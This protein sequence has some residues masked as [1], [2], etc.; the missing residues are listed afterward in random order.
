MKDN[1]EYIVGDRN[2]YSKKYLKLKSTQKTRIG[3]WI[4]DSLNEF[5]GT[6][7][8][9]PEEDGD[10]EEVL[11]LI[12]VHI[13]KAGIH[14]S[15]DEI[16]EHYCSCR[17]RKINQ[18]KKKMEGI[19]L[20]DLLVIERLPGEFSVCKVMDYSKTDLSVSFTF[21][22]VTDEEYSL[23]CPTCNVP[24]NTIARE[25]AWKG[26]RINGQLD[27]SLTGILNRITTALKTKK[28]SLFAV[29]TYNTDYVFVKKE[30]Y[31]EALRLVKGYGFRIMDEQPG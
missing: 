17:I 27:F 22:G 25:D 31:E 4:S 18:L 12:M 11:N 15:D 29:S 2:K 1:Y 13:K 16:Y 8:R 20:S 5:Y 28:I 23:V 24:E 3:Q 14:I 10:D 26:F 19:P 9:W 6:Y 7:G 21:I 30:R